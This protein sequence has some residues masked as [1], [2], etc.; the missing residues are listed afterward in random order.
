MN[1]ETIKC[2]NFRNLTD[3]DFSPVK[4]VN[5][6]CGDNGQG[7]TNLL[8]AI[9]ML[10][11]SKSFRCTKDSLLINKDSEFSEIKSEFIKENRIQNIRI[12]IAD[13]KRTASL[14][15]GSPTAASA[16]SG[17]FC[18]VIFSPEHLMMVKGSPD[19]RRKFIDSSLFQ[20]Y[21]AYSGYM[22]KYI[23]V[24]NQRNSLIKDANYISAAYEMIDVL[25]EQL[26]EL[27]VKITEYRKNYIEK[28]NP[29]AQER[30][31]KIADNKEN[32][33]ISYSSSIFTYEKPNIES[34]I[35]ILQE[36]RVNDLK[37]GFTTVGPH[38][39]DLSIRIN[40]NDSKVFASQGQQRSI[41]L[42]V[43]LA[44]AEMLYK[45]TGE[46]PVLLL[47]DVMSELDEA[48]GEHLLKSMDSM[49]AVITTCNHE[50]IS[51]RVESKI[52]KM[53]N[54]FLS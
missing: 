35:E 20:L 46:Y 40:G 39:D 42:S 2:L 17:V 25:D 41:V 34:C 28:L 47:D 18:C 32:I 16:L 12:N 4:G 6:V 27:T 22:K 14:N 33:T 30:Y 3:L 31:E 19:L 29:L 7:K 38:R 24:L 11:G 5:I 10:T 53:E 26:S 13:N 51:K 48:R 50:L 23:R 45:N 1:L 15:E 8:E 36:N 43:K 9:Y 37:A 21:P 54:G 49:Q 44:E 52:Y